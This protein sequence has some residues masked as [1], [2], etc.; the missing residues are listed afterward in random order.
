M[1]QIWDSENQEYYQVKGEDNMGTETTANGQELMMAQ[2]AKLMTQME[3]L[4]AENA[5][6]KTSKAVASNKVAAANNWEMHRDNDNLV[7]VVNL[8]EGGEIETKSKKSKIISVIKKPVPF[9]FGADGETHCNCDWGDAWGNITLQVSQA[10]PD[11]Y[12]KAKE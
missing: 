2:I 10:K 11:A 8:K 7:I 9:K 3:A 12:L 4:T 5:E 6:L 1:R